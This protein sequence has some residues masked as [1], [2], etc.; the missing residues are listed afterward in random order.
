MRSVTRRFAS[1]SVSRSGAA[2]SATGSA[3][4]RISPPTGTRIGW[5]ACD[6]RDEFVPGMSSG[7]H[8]HDAI[9]RERRVELDREQRGVGVGR[10]D[11]GPVPGAGEH[12]VVG[13]QGRAGELGGALAARRD[14]DAPGRSGRCG[15]RRPRGRLDRQPGAP[16]SK[17]VQGCDRVTRGVKARRMLTQVRPRRRARPGRRPGVLPAVDDRDAVDEHVGDALRELARLLVRGEGPH[18]RRVEHDEV[19]RQP[20]RDPAAVGQPQPRR[21]RAGHAV[22]RRLQ[23]QPALLAHEL[24]EDPRDTSRTTAARAC[25]R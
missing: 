17:F 22:D 21:R 7:G 18:R 14:G 3:W 6:A 12:H 24:P 19:R 9:P 23:P 11:R 13:V 1:R 4:C 2:I 15:M 8:D 20:I 10:A 16:P 25:R 5:S